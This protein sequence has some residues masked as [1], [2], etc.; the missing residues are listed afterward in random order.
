MF[1]STPLFRVHAQIL[2]CSTSG[3]YP[4]QSVTYTPSLELIFIYKLSVTP[5]IHHLLP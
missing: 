1:L 5:P 2:F 4:Q 3:V